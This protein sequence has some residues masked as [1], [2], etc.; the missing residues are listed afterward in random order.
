MVQDWKV[1]M[2]KIDGLELGGGNAQRFLERPDVRKLLYDKTE[3]EP[4]RKVIEL[5]RKSVGKET[6]FLSCAARVNR[7]LAGF[8]SK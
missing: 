7:A 5:I 8:R 6:F 1:D 2:L 3:K 4:F